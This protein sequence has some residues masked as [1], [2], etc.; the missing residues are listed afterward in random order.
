[1]DRGTGIFRA[2]EDHRIGE[3]PFGILQK[4]CEE[5]CLVAAMEQGVAGALVL[6][7]RVQSFGGFFNNDKST[8]ETLLALVA[9][10]KFYLHRKLRNENNRFTPIEGD[11]FLR[12]H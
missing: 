10:S 3:E 12:V 6:L 9:T 11:G 2:Y 8:E 7:Y 5:N 4:N 1:M